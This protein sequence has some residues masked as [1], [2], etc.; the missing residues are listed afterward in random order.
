MAKK[1]RACECTKASQKEVVIE[2]CRGV[3]RYHPEDRLLNKQVVLETISECLMHGDEEGALEV[4]HIHV[5]ALS[6]KR[7]I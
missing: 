5:K 3:K 6:R 1:I 4:F 7:V 2:G